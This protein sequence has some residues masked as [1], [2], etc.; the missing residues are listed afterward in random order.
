MTTTPPRPIQPGDRAPGF[1]LPAINREGT[2]SLDEYRGKQP[3]LVGL[4]RGLSC[5]FCR[6]HLVQLSATQD[7]LKPA[8]VETVGVVNTTLDRARLYFKYRP[9]RIPLAADPEATTHRAYGVPEFQVADTTQWPYRVTLEELRSVRM[10][11][12]GELPAPLS[13]LEIGAEL[14]RRD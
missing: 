1:S 9:T 4:F 10:N 14:N 5:P 2:V 7:K 12:T 13:P 11:P 3:V 8:G 6:R